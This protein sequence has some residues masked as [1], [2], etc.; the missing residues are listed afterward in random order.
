MSYHTIPGPGDQCHC[1]SYYACRCQPEPDPDVLFDEAYQRGHDACM[2]DGA[3]N[4]PLAC[5]PSTP[6]DAALARDWRRLVAGHSI[7]GIDGR[8][9]YSSHWFN[10]LRPWQHRGLYGFDPFRREPC[11]EGYLAGFE[12]AMAGLPSAVDDPERHRAFA[13]ALDAYEPEPVLYDWPIGPMPAP[14][15]DDDWMPF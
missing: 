7:V 5:W 6:A 15:E 3:D 1:G 11:P 14:A 4:H 12:D 8:R 9:F 2:S 10:V 13:A